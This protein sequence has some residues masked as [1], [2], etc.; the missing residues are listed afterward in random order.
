MTTPNCAAILQ[1]V[2]EI[3]STNGNLLRMSGSIPEYQGKRLMIASAK[4]LDACEIMLKL[5]DEMTVNEIP[6]SCLS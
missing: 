1:A 6:P 5:C 2:K 4:L 3:S